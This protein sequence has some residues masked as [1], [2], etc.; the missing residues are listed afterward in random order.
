MDYEFSENSLKYLKNIRK[1]NSR[2][3][4]LN[5][6]SDYDLYLVKPFQYIVGEL[7]PVMLNIDPQIETTP[8]IDK[9]I[10]RIYRDTRFSSDKSL[11]RDSM[12]LTFMK[13]TKEKADSP[14]FFFEITPLSYRYG[15]GFFSASVKTM[16]SYRDLIMNKENKFLKIISKIKLGKIFVP[17][18]ELYKK[19]KYPGKIEEISEWYNR[20][21]IYLINNQSNVK[22]I[23]DM[24]KLIKQLKDGFMGLNEIYIFLKEA[25][26]SK[27][28]SNG[29]F[30]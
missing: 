1:N 30:V 27:T 23:F 22:N 12:W 3:W 5:N 16:N 2:E 26:N 28:E 21:N 13:R 14:A 8:A 9:T 6:K 29:R 7:S 20:K 15:M 25:V 4:Y 19:N 11:Y 18:G 24:E 10:S 17:E